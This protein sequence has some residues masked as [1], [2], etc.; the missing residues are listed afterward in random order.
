MKTNLLLKAALISSAVLLA[1]CGGPKDVDKI[2]DAQD[3]LD[4]AATSEVADCVAKVDGMESESAY[5]IRC[6]GKFAKEGY[7]DT[8]KL[9]T[10]LTGTSGT[11]TGATGSLSMMASLAFK[12]ESTAALNSASATEAAD[13]CVKSKSKGL[14]SL[15][16]LAKVATVTG[17]LG[18]Q[19]LN[20]LDGDALKTLMGTL[21]SD[22]NAQEAVGSAVATIYQSTCTNDS[23]TAGNFCQQFES[24]LTAVPGGIDNTSALGEQIMKC[25]NDPTS[26]GCTGF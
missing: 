7:N 14:I 11:D 3:C 21:Q 19:D 25:Y 2:A 16:N 5:L 15:A 6:V 8:T 22:P 1:S 18:G 10:A 23:K 13:F 17:Y 12:A 20:T 4:H 24:A 26:A 9:A